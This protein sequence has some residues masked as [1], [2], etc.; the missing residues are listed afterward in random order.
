MPRIPVRKGTRVA[1]M[2]HAISGANEQAISALEQNA[3]RPAEMPG[4][5]DSPLSPMGRLQAYFAG[6][7]LR[8]IFPQEDFRRRG[9]VAHSTLERA[10][11]TAKLVMH[12]GG[13]Q[14]VRILQSDFLAERQNARTQ[15]DDYH[16]QIQPQAKLNLGD[17]SDMRELIRQDPL[18]ARSLEGNPDLREMTPLLLTSFRNSMNHFYQAALAKNGRVG[19]ETIRELRKAAAIKALSDWGATVMPKYSE[20]LMAQDEL[21]LHE[22]RKTPSGENFSDLKKRVQKFFD[23]FL[24]AQ[25]EVKGGALAYVVTHSFLFL[26]L[27]QYIEGFSNQH[28]DY[29]LEQD[30]PPFP[31]HVGIVLYKE[32]NGFLVRDMPDGVDYLIPPEFEVHGRRLRFKESV[33]DSVIREACRVT[34]VTEFQRS[35]NR[36][37]VNGKRRNSDQR[38]KFSFPPERSGGPGVASTKPDDSDS[39]KKAS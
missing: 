32:E 7:Y 14:P 31:T 22:Q 24:F 15:I 10:R 17:M 39:E 34:G 19:P 5:H 12:Y 9:L 8:E 11:Q 25:A 21:G 16:E 36:Y 1:A 4:Q 20:W 2:R 27:R 26:A 30:G 28:L 3:Q 38:F 37:R 29:I 33:P 35:K 6:K 18:I 23:D 13:L